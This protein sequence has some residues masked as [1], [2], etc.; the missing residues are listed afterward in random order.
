MNKNL[1]KIAKEHCDLSI[2]DDNQPFHLRS[3]S[4]IPK[5]AEKI[6]NAIKQ[7][8]GKKDGL[9]KTSRGYDELEIFP[10]A[11]MGTL[12]VLLGKREE[13]DEIYDKINKMPWRF[14]S[15]LY[16]NGK[17]LRGQYTS[18]N[19]AMGVF[20]SL[21]GKEE[22][23]EEL[24]IAIKEKIETQSGLY[25]IGANLVSIYPLDN[26]LMGAFEKLMGN[27]VAAER[28]YNEIN[29]VFGKKDDLY[30]HS[31][32]YGME[33]T[34]L[35]NAAMAVLCQLIGKETEAA[36]IIN[37][38]ELFVEGTDGLLNDGKSFRYTTTEVNALIG[39]YY[40]LKVRGLT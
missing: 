40:C 33:P 28:L 2:I 5:E 35:D 37:A 18:D 29:S 15:G 12:C 13:A 30:I 25:K 17:T 8:I 1:L 6:Y 26:A 24:D 14:G 7:S 22:E 21:L 11:L 23:V 34:G 20:C 36:D 16:Y 4:V 31:K 9:Y 39:I 38:Y 32:E 19:A 3:K 10:N 27:D